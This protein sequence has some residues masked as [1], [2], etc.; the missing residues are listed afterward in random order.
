MALEQEIIEAKRRKMELASKFRAFLYESSM[1]KED[2]LAW[3]EETNHSF[4]NETTLMKLDAE[5]FCDQLTDF[6]LKEAEQLKENL[7]NQQ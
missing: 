4:Q 1:R 7:F 2:D 3:L 6:L 5:Y